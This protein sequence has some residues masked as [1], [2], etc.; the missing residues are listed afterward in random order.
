MVVPLFWKLSAI[1]MATLACA[2]AVWEAGIN[3][4]W[5]R[6]GVGASIMWCLLD[7]R[8]EWLDASLLVHIAQWYLSIW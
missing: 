3:N 4:L 2:Q 5:L 6:L 1:A 7:A 8:L